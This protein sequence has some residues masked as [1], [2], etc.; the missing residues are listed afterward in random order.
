MKHTD[1][2]GRLALAA[3]AA[4]AITTGSWSPSSAAG[5]VVDKIHFFIPGGAGGKLNAA[6]L[7][8]EVKAGS[9]GFSEALALAKAGKMRILAV[10]SAKRVPA[11]AAAIFIFQMNFRKTKFVGTGPMNGIEL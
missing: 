4:A 8:G 9:T 3:F 5:K 11:I 10:T 1:S 7:S 2:T 6:I